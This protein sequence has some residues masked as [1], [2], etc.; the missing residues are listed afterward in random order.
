[1]TP[2][3]RVVATLAERKKGY[4]SIPVEALIDLA[5]FCHAFESCFHPD[6]RIHAQIEGRREVW[7]RIT[8]Y[9]ELTPHQLAA[10]IH[11]LKS[12]PTNE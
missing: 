3:Q 9:L 11:G 4:E 7:V 1:M 5:T 10:V 8:H 2:Y 6:P 12:E